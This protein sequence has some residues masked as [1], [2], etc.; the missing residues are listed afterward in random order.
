MAILQLDNGTIYRE[1]SDIVRELDSL[2]IRV[3][4][5]TSGTSLLFPNLFEQDILAEPEKQQILELH[6]SVFEF[7]KQ[8]GSYLWSDLL[9]LHPG[10]P[11][12]QTLAATYSRYH[13]HP[14]PETLHVLAG[15]AIF[16]F[17]QHD[18]SQMQLL[19][20]AQDYIHIPI[21]V[22][23]WFSLAASLH[24]KAVRYFTTAAGWMPYYT[25]TQTG[26]RTV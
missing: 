2:N 8:E 3:K 25:E 23:H 4:Q 13:T 24:V 7:I 10:S 19:L 1:L 12:L 14:D 21:G 15:E 9:V 5:Y 17:V 16:S 11:N 18:G 6:D 20:Q 26:D 22:E